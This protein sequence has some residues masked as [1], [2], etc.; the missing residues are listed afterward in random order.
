LVGKSSL[1]IEIAPASYF[2]FVKLLALEQMVGISE[3]GRWSSGK[4]L[5][6]RALN[7]LV[8]DYRYFGRCLTTRYNSKRLCF[9]VNDT[10]QLIEWASIGARFSNSLLQTFR[11]STGDCLGVNRGWLFSRAP[12]AVCHAM[13]CRYE[14]AGAPLGVIVSCCAS[15]TATCLCTVSSDSPP[16]IFLCAGRDMVKE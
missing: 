2:P 5:S 10:E 15:I 11:S 7:V 12:Q 13:R 6:T 16:T 1:A 4:V 14:Q 8:S 9:A 3:A